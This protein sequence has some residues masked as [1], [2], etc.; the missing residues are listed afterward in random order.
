MRSPTC[1]VFLNEFPKLALPSRLES[2]IPV[3]YPAWI[4]I[5]EVQKIPALLNKVH[6]LSVR[7]HCFTQL[8]RLIAM[9]TPSNPY[10]KKRLK[11]CC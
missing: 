5:D 8:I 4:I 10:S 11:W 3:G 7:F 1:L 6:R 2:L 9:T